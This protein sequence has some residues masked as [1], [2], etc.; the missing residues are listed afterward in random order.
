[1]KGH[2]SLLLK[3]AAIVFLIFLFWILAPVLQAQ[4]TEEM[5]E[6]TQEWRKRPRFSL[7]FGTYLA[8]LD[9]KLRLDSVTLGRGTEIKL[10]DKLQFDKSPVIFRGEG[11]IRALSWFGL[12]LGFYSINRSN[13]TVI[14]EEI[15]I[16]DTVFNINQTI[17]G[18]FNTTYV[19]TNLKFYLVN[20]PRVEFG[21]WAGANI[22]FLDLSLT[23][24]ELG[25]TIGES[26][27]IW[28]PI[29]AAGIHASYT[30][31]RNFYFFGKVGYFYY[32]L[33]ENLKFKSLSF[34]INMHYYFYKF[35]GI[36]ATF[37]Y[38]R[39]NLDGEFEDLSGIARNRL[40]G[41]QLYAL[42]GF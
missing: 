14:D 5:I 40:S 41:I 23:A 39:F 38:N 32:G 31:F 18:K 22:L 20:K 37:E 11:E 16:G 19:K 24:Q 33:S 9:T 35:L 42:I 28:A 34:D 17:N 25:E 10:E 30:L 15:Q 26:Q 4:E 29:P 6:S 13:S 7:R 8:D 27:D 2:K 1:M 36:G 12:E 21:V 3:S